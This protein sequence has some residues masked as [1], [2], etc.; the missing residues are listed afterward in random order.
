M[1][2][3]IIIGIAAV[4]V[5]GLIVLAYQI[6][7]S[8]QPAPSESTGQNV[9]LPS[10]SSVGQ[11]I[12][13]TSGFTQGNSLV[14]GGIQTL[15]FVNDPATTKDPLNPGYYYL[16]YHVSEGTSDPT[17]TN[18]SPYIITYISAT[19]YFNIAL[20]QEPIGTAREDA[21]QYLM[22]HLGIT[23]DQMCRLDYM[24]SVPWR[25]NQIYSGENLGFSF[26]PGA[27]VLPQ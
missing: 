26:C 2:K 22:A 8:T 17:A 25:V 4:I 10:S 23:Q 12:G 14:G 13:T 15:D 3:L 21:Q 27:T 6:A 1:K 11:N 20:M 16:G 24:V 18:N 19:H 7:G 5:I 9:G